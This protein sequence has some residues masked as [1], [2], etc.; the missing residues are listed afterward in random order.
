MGR[1]SKFYNMLGNNKKERFT[2]LMILIIILCSFIVLSINLGYNK[3][4]GCYWK[5]ADV[6]INKKVGNKKNRDRHEEEYK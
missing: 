6:H 5:P 4:Q 2:R 1:L 3:T